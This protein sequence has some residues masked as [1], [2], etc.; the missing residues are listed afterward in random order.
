FLGNLDSAEVYTRNALRI[1][2]EIKHLE[3]LQ[4]NYVSL[5]EIAKRRKDYVSALNNVDRAIAVCLEGK[6]PDGL[7]N[8]YKLM[9][10]I[11]ADKGDFKAA[12]EAHKRYAI[13]NDSLNFGDKITNME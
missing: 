10:E 9:A 3:G 7:I 5:A 2:L 4:L 12:Y 8:S 6:F 11:Y 1:N 13:Y